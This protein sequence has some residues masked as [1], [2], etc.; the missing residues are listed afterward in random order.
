MIQGERVTLETLRTAR[1]KLKLVF[2]PLEVAGLEGAIS[3][4]TI[5]IDPRSRIPLGK[6]LVHEIIHGLYP[7]W[8][9]TRVVKEERRLWNSFSWKE[10]AE[11]FTWLGKAPIWNGEGCVPA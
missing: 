5:V 10:K 6:T 8:S 4:D 1:K 3:G 7:L 2:M 11:V 9:E